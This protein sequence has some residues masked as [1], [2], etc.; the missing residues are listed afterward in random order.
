MTTSA[1]RPATVARWHDLVAHRDGPD[2]AARLDAFLAPDA[3]F[4]SPAVHRVQEG[5]VLTAA[6]LRAAL[7]V[8][9]P[10]LRYEREWWGADSAVLE[11]A[12]DLDGREVHGVD[13]MRWG[14]DGRVVEFTVMVRPLRGLE[15]L[16]EL[17]GAELARG[18]G[19]S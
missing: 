10:R 9:G 14:D 1:D 4:R 13:M 12:A 11:F 6:Y 7:V 18:R 3:V 16:V 5:R 2:V 17:M 15:A 8:L 19:A